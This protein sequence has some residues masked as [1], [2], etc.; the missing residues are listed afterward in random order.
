[1]RS[2]TD[3]MGPKGRGDYDRLYLEKSGRGKLVRPRG[4]GGKRE[5]PGE[6]KR[7]VGE[8]PQEKTFGLRKANSWG[9]GED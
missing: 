9:K 6:G 4:T 5:G 3:T 8:V 1:M 7:V 2:R